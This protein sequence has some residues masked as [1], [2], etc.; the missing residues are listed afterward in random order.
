MK[1]KSDNRFKK[2]NFLI[3]RQNVTMF[4]VDFSKKFWPFFFRRLRIKIINS[5]IIA[6]RKRLKR[7]SL[8]GTENKHG[9]Y[10]FNR[11]YNFRLSFEV[12]S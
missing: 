10:F 9:A 1:A 4:P 11:R 5:Y 7:K 2:I 8:M 3:N 6:G 12:I